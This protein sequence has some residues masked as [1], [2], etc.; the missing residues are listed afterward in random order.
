MLVEIDKKSIPPTI[1]FEAQ[2][3]D[4]N[5]VLGEIYQIFE[6]AVKGF[7]IRSHNSVG[8][9]VDELL[10]KMTKKESTRED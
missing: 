8:V 3:L 10:K 9:Q 2:T 7:T 5:V 6:T 1:W 4:D